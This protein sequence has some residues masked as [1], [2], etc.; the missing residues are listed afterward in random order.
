MKKQHLSMLLGFLIFIFFY[1]YLYWLGTYHLL[2]VDETRYVNMAREMFNTKDYLTLYLNGEY[3]F[4]KPPLFFNLLCFSFKILGYINEY[5]ARL[6]IVLLSLLPLILLF[7][8]CIKAKGTKFAIISSITLL[9]TLEYIFMTKLAILDSVFTSFISSSILCY[10]YTFYTDKKNKKYFWSFTYIFSALA[11][12]SKGI[13]GIIIPVLIIAICS[14]IFKTQKESF[15]YSWGLILFLIIVLPWHLI[16]L[17]MHGVSFFDEYIVKHHI[18]RFLGS[19]II[20]KNQPWY[21]YILTLLWGLFPHIFIFLSQIT[22]INLKDKFIILNLVAVASI[23][24]FFSL[25]GA[26][27]IT[28]ILPIYP[29]FAVAIGDIWYKF[30]NFGNKNAY[31]SLIILNLFFTISTIIMLFIKFILP[32]EIYAN[33]QNLQIFSLIILIP[34]VIFNWIFI[35]KMRKLKF[36]L[37]VSV[38]MA[39]I[40]GFLTPHIF[41]FN[42]TFGQNDL[43]KFARYAKEKNYTISTYLTGRKYS[44]LYYGEKNEIKFQTK[45]DLNWFNYELNKKNHIIILRNKEIENLQISPK[46]KGIKYSMIEGKNHAK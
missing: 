18:L 14:F 29:F 37:S 12:L 45:K 36:F 3:F 26:K 2:D 17:K 20:N 42:Y 38:L 11:V 7:T 31:I 32:S 39:L 33:F 24:V 23:L 8:L 15:R 22:K 6:P 25:S 16:M 1:G 40:S 10:F 34:S 44:L 19:D 9:T 30:I 28:Y 4:E 41:E 35:I 13:P 27:L 21:F 46:L 5:S 43:M